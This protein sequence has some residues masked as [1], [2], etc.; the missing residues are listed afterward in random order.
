MTENKKYNL[1]KTFTICL[2]IL[3]I[4][5]FSSCSETTTEHVDQEENMRLNNKTIEAMMARAKPLI[6]EITGRKFKSKIDF[7]IISRKALRQN[8][9][10]K[11]LNRL[12]EADGI[13]KFINKVLAGL[14]ARKCSQFYI[15]RYFRRDRILYVIPENIS[16]ARKLYKIE[17][18]DLDDFLFI[19]I[20]HEMVHAID[21]QYYNIPEIQDRIEDLEETLALNAVMGGSAAY[22]T[23]IIADKLIIPETSYKSSL[24]L[25]IC[26][27]DE[28]NP[29]ENEYYN[30]YYVKGAE[31]IRTIIKRKGVLAGYDSAFTS[32]PVSTRQILFP[33]EYFN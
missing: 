16:K 12:E 10:E 5:L 4:N 24:K 11:S 17:D 32:P 6:E 30:L 7:R 31:F 14:S 25:D 2:L 33:E 1:L 26:L 28:N 8:L 18:K 20:A 9:M 29:S 3:I 23:S 22:V 19:I 13:G 21:N 27:E 15:G